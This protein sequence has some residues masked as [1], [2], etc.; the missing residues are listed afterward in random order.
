MRQHEGLDRAGEQKAPR[1]LEAFCPWT[2]Q[3]TML[4]REQAR[5]WMPSPS[6]VPTRN[7]REPVLLR[8][9]RQ[10][11]QRWH[12]P[13]GDTE[14]TQERRRK[15]WPRKAGGV[16]RLLSHLGQWAACGVRRVVT[17]TVRHSDVR[18]LYVPVREEKSSPSVQ[19]SL[20]TQTQENR[21]APTIV[22]VFGG[23]KR[24][25]AV[26]PHRVWGTA[27][28]CRDPLHLLQSCPA[29]PMTQMVP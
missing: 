15:R 21:R 25:Q 18:L 9:K 28:H 27:W 26:T 5:S 1:P 11:R 6:T 13:H 17:R 24:P 4:M 2:L 16:A 29:T 7:T 3:V 20:V 22:F 8:T 12:R 23:R 10:H 19:T 14:H